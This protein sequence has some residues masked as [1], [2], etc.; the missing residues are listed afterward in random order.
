MDVVRVH[1]VHTSTGQS[2]SRWSSTYPRLDENSSTIIGFKA[3][4]SLSATLY[5]LPGL[6]HQSAD[7]SF[8]ID[9]ISESK[10]VSCKDQSIEYQNRRLLDSEE[11]EFV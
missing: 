4:V 6:V 1:I 10:D 5:E 8:Q 3:Q 11:E 2:T 9:W 7:D